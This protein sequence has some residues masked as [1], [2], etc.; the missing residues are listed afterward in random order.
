[1]K[2]LTVQTILRLM[3]LVVVVAAV[4]VL[5]K[6]AAAVIVNNITIPLICEHLYFVSKR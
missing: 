1:M 6:T 2:M 3:V 5:V 4:V